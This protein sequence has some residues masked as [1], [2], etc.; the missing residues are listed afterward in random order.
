MKKFFLIDYDHN[1]DSIYQDRLYRAAAKIALKYGKF[2]SGYLN[3]TEEKIREFWDRDDDYP[4]FGYFRDKVRVP[5]VKWYIHERINSPDIIWDGS[6]L[7]GLSVYGNIKWNTCTFPSFYWTTNKTIVSLL[8]SCPFGGDLV[9][10]SQSR[11]RWNKAPSL[12][13]RSDEN[14]ISFMAGLLAAGTLYEKDDLTYAKYNANQKRYLKEWNIPIESNVKAHV[15]ISPIW[16]ALFTPRM[17]EE[18]RDA[19]KNVYHPFGV[20]MYPP[21]LWR[22]YVNNTFPTRGIPYLKSRRWIFQYYKSEKGA[23]K[24]LE[25]LRVEKNLTEIDHNVR[26]MV[27]EWRDM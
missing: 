17:P 16:P 11:Y 9:E 25:R 20:K 2:G 19:W 6:F 14:S 13:L 18:F 27:H 12:Y 3:C 7:Q 1:K 23:M 22:T 26:Q 5:I 15:L 24:K 4:S 8:K 10:Y 21:I